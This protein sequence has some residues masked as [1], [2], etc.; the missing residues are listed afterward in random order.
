MANHSKTVSF[1]CDPELFS[2]LQK[3]Q[4]QAPQG[5]SDWIRTTLSGAAFRAYPLEP[6]P[7]RE[8]FRLPY[9]SAVAVFHGDSRSLLSKLVG[10]EILVWNAAGMSRTAIVKHVRFRSANRVVVDIDPPKIFPSLRRTEP[11]SL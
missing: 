9:D 2:H 10:Y 4:R 3:V 11:P 7:S 6:T 8:V 5:L 1:R